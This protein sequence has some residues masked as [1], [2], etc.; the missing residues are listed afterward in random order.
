MRMRERWLRPAVALT[1]L[2]FVMLAA[3]GAVGAASG[4]GGHGD[5]SEKITD[6]FAR[7]LNFAILAGALVFLLR[8]PVKNFF[9]G[10]NKQIES[11]FSEV[12]AR[13]EKIRAEFDEISRKLKEI[14]GE[15]EKI[16]AGYVREGEAEKR[17]II[18]SA[19]TMSRRI[20]EQAQITINMEI[21][22]AREELQEEIAEL[23]TNMA[24]EIIRNNM[25]PDDQK[26]LANEYV[27]KV[28][29]AA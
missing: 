2:A 14:E 17:K 21:K 19:Q 28:V 13:K 25:K 18:E 8:K 22:K 10:R 20:E 5:E 23:A 29:K 16:V 24:E 9:G 27:E 4:G 3:V 1:V 6:L 7:I 12:R 26:R 11:E 15:R